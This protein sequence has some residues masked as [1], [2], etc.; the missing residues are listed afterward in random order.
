[1]TNFVIKHVKSANF[2]LF[3]S[4]SD[5]ENNAIVKTICQR[6]IKPIEIDLIYNNLI[7]SKVLTLLLHTND[8]LNSSRSQQ[9]LKNLL[10]MPINYL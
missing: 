8:L 1:M 9:Q 3:L 2:T 5:I 6:V 10:Q 7:K 4:E